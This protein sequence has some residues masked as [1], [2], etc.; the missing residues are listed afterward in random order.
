[1]GQTSL[2]PEKNI[3]L[4]SPSQLAVENS[5]MFK[6]KTY[7]E[8]K[9]N[10]TLSDYPSF[11]FWSIEHAEDF[12]SEYWDYAGLIGD[13]G[14]VVI[15][16]KDQIEQAKFFPEARI[17]YAENML[18][19]RDDAP[20]IIFKTEQG[21]ERTDSFADV[22]A[23]VSKIRQAMVDEGIEKGDRIAAYMPN[24]PETIYVALAAASLGAIFSS[25]SPDF[26]AGGVIDRFG[27]TEP[28]L[29]F[30]VDHYYY[31]GKN[32]DQRTKLADI[33]PALPSVQKAII[34]P[35]VQDDLDT[36]ALPNT[37]RYEDFIAP[38]AVQDIA[39]TRVEFNHPLYIM[40][41]SGTTG[42]PKCIVHGHGGTLIQHVKE[43]SLHCDLKKGERIFYYTTCGWMM[44]NW[45]ISGLAVDATV[46]LYDGSPFHED[47]HILWDFTT[48]HKCNVFGTSAK[49]IEALKTNHIYPKEHYDLSDLRMITSTGSPLVH[50]GFDFVYDHIKSDVHLA[51]IY[52][53]TD[54]ITASFGIGNPISPVYRGELQGSALGVDVQ[55]FDDEGQ[56]MAEGTGAGELVCV[57]AHPSMPVGF[58]NDPD[59]AKYHKAYFAEYENIWHH[60]DWV[61][62]TLNHGLIVHGRSDATLN[63][64]GVRIG[65]AEIYRQVEKIEDV[66]ESICVGQ[67]WEGDV[68]VILFVVMKPGKT[69][70]EDL[71]KQIRTQIRVGASPRHMP[72]KVIAVADI[73][74]TRS[75]KITEIA[76]RDVIHGR[77]VKNVEAL[78]NPESLEL[79]KDIAELAV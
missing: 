31:G 13:K 60:G 63:P 46:L 37:M 64:G 45:L 79:Y 66:A 11:Y 8:K 44:W 77:K 6:F 40:F 53:G 36:S 5:N 32:L 61:E 67:N 23:A 1:M 19:R 57:N 30:T 48:R 51:S 34:I 65:T 24:M 25:A 21:P 27:Q 47:G 7:L 38:Y 54:V 42:A 35:N 2:M 9:Y 59:G 17:N 74:R 56:P 49:Y 70:N 22:Y 3:P 72:A 50:E 73:P 41:S 39:F 18:K 71:I 62:K 76:V 52:G 29:L 68:R 43:L 14:N 78:A 12:W 15:A 20:A 75:G 69:L 28:K 4:W 58:W 55:I 10:V 33:L 26:G 16:N